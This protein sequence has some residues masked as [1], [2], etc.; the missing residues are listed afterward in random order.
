MR[1]SHRCPFCRAKADR[2]RPYWDGGV[3]LYQCGDCGR[4][5][6]HAISKEVFRSEREADL[7]WDDLTY[8]DIE[9]WRKLPAN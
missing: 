4:R 6:T 7:V 2:L 8:E 3:R 9:A 5:H 1:Q